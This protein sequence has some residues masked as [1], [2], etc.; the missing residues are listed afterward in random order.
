MF[1][2]LFLFDIQLTTVA[3]TVAKQFIEGESSSIKG[4]CIKDKS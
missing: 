1:Y 3:I 2:I 4:K